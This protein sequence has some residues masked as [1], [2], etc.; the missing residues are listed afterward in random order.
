MPEDE[1]TC[2]YMRLEESEVRVDVKCELS[3]GTECMSET[4]ISDGSARGC[5]AG[6]HVLRVTAMK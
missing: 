1:C 6:H 5:M 2:V 3:E 4:S